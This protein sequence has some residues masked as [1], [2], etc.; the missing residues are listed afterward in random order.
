[1]K[2]VDLQRL[3]RRFD[4]AQVTEED[5]T[6]ALEDTVRE[7]D[8]VDRRFDTAK[9]AM[10]EGQAAALRVR[11]AEAGDAVDR[12]RAEVRA[13]GLPP[14]ETPTEFAVQAVLARDKKPTAWDEGGNISERDAE[15]ES[16]IRP[17]R[18]RRS[19]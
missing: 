15:W 3:R 2:A 1:M 8:A 6:I 4:Q 19:P 9:A 14:R 16:P 10:L 5:L 11:L 13:A 18:P 17:P 12:L 7:L